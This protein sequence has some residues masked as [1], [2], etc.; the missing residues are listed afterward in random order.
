MERSI[1]AKARA[2]GPQAVGIVGAGLTRIF[3]FNDPHLYLSKTGNG[4]V[5]VGFISP[6]DLR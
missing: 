1:R 4:Q 2:E 3:D 6:K 5:W